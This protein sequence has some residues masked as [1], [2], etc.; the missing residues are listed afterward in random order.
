MYLIITIR[1]LLSA[2][3]ELKP[4]SEDAALCSFLPSPPYYTYE[5]LLLSTETRLVIL[6]NANVSQDK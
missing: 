3:L 6:V 5:L 2:E 1:S 4:C